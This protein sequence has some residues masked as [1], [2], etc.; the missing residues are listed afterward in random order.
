VFVVV[1]WWFCGRVEVLSLWLCAG[2]VVV[3]WRRWKV[4]KYE[5]TWLRVAGPYR[6]RDCVWCYCG[7]VVVVLW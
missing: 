3:L 2:V 4:G 5:P 1:L 6:K 7:C